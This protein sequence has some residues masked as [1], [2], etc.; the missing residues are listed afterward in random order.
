MATTIKTTF[1]SIYLTAHLPEE[2]SIETDAAR[3][4]V[5]I[6][7]D[8]VKVFK[9]VYYPF[10]KM[11]SVRDIRSIIEASMCERQLVMATLKMEIYEPKSSVNT[12]TSVTIDENGNYVVT[13]GSDGSA[14]PNASLDN[15]KMVYCRF[16]SDISSEG[17]LG[18]RFLTTRKSALMSHNGKLSLSNYTKAYVQGSNNALIYYSHP[19]VPEQI[20]SYHANLGKMQSATEKIV[21]AEL[22]YDYFKSMVDQARGTN[23][24]VHGVEYRI[25]VRQFNIF[26]TDEKPTETFVFLNAFNIMETAY[27]YNTTSIKTEVDRIEAVCGHRTQFYDETVKVKHEVE[28]APLTYDEAKWLNQMLTSKLVK[29]PISVDES[30]QVLISDISS[31]VTDSDKELIRI[32]FSWKYVDGTEWI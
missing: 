24:K 32:K 3:L 20:F 15:V 26:F 10:D 4:E 7:V 8:D 5:N 21:T 9:S 28:T 1:D 19:Q 11:V 22:S 12:P 13:Y 18:C 2:V 25:G 14:S 17:Y 30:A 29:R 6:F 31:E 23:C 27:L 16:K